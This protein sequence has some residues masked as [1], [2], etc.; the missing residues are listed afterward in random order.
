MSNLDPAISST[1]AAQESALQTQIQFALAGKAL[2]AARQ[3]GQTAV[4]LLESAAQI[5]PSINTGSG[6]DGQA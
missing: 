2:E 4:Q 3:S 5:S 1:L 6:F